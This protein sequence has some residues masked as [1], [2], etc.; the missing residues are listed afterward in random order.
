MFEKYTRE[1]TA[2]SDSRKLARIVMGSLDNGA[3]TFI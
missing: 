3:P 1:V 2:K